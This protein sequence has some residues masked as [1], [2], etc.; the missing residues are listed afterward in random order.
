[1][2]PKKCVERRARTILGARFIDIFGQQVATRY[3]TGR[4]SRVDVKDKNKPL[5]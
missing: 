5:N 3:I 2:S 4:L 1:M